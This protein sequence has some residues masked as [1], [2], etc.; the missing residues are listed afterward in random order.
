[1]GSVRRPGSPMLLLPLSGEDRMGYKIKDEIEFSYDIE[2][3]CFWDNWT[4]QNGS[5]QHLILSTIILT[6]AHM[7]KSAVRICDHSPFI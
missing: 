3:D 5:R 2:E 7:A 6:M 1:M 4:H